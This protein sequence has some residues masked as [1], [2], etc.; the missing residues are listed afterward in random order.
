MRCVYELCEAV[1]ITQ[2]P[3]PLSYYT[4]FFIFSDFNRYS[5]N[6]PSFRHLGL[7]I[8]YIYIRVGGVMSISKGQRFE[9]TVHVHSMGRFDIHSISWFPLPLT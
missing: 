2:N 7:A 6:F 8:Y 1:G 4:I 9:V 3:I 5:L